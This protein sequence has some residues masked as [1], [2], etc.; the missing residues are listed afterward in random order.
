MPRKKSKHR[1]V[2][3]S[4]K[5]KGRRRTRVGKLKPRGRPNPQ[6][7]RPW[8]KGQSGNPKGLPHWYRE[9]RALFRENSEPAARRIVE[10]ARDASEKRLSLAACEAIIDR[11]GLQPFKVEPDRHEVSVNSDLDGAVVAELA[12]FRTRRDAARV[13]A[14]P[15]RANEA[16]S[17]RG[18]EGTRAALAPA[19]GSADGGLRKPG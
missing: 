16:P 15:D 17:A 8:K 5:S 3:I 9:L 7:L 13:P 11:A 10:L 14:G 6:N 12:A 19:A 2:S 1:A 4:G 18:P